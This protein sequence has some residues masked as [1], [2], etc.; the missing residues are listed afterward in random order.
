MR[1][2][3][4]VEGLCLGI[5]WLGLTFWAGLALDYLPVLAGANEMPLAARGVVLTIIAVGLAFILYRWVLRRSF[6]PLADRSLAVLLERRFS[7]F[8]DSLVTAV[9]LT[10]HP[11]HA[12][13][14]DATMLQETSR[15]ALVELPAARLSRLFNYGPLIRGVVGAA[16][17][18]ASVLALAAVQWEAWDTWVHR[19][20]LLGDNTWPRR[21]QIEVVGVELLGPEDAGDRTAD[22]PLIEFR[23][24]ALKVAK[25]SNLRLRVR[26][27]LGA[28][29][30]P[31]VCT[32]Y[33][34][35]ADGERGRASMNRTKRSR[36]EYQN[37]SYADKPLRGILSTIQ[38]DVLGADC[39]V[40]DYT[41]E[42]VDSPAMVVT[43]LDCKFPAYLVDER[44]SLWLP[45]T[46][47][48]ANAT[49][50]P[51]GTDV[52]I[53]AQ[54][55]KPLERVELYNPDTKE[56][57]TLTITGAGDERQRFSYHVSDLQEN[58]TLD[59]TLCDVDQ[60]VTER[61]QRLFVPVVEDEAPRIDAR[62]RGIG[63]AVTPDVM[64]PATGT[65]TDDYAVAK[66][67]F[68]VETTAASTPQDQPKSQRRTWDFPLGAGG[69]VEAVLDCRQWRSLTDGPELKPKDK[70]TLAIKAA[71][72]FN[73]GAS[74][75]NVGSGD[76]YQL[77]VVTPETLL[78]M[79]ESREIGLRR[80]F[81]QIVQEVT[82]CRDLI[83]RTAKPP[84]A[85]K[86][87]P[88]DAAVGKEPGEKQP[89]P[90]KAAERVQ[91][92]RLLRVQQA[93][94]QARKSAQELLG[95]A[96][97]FRDIREELI[98]NRVDTEDRKKRLQEMIADPM[99][100]AGETLFPELDRRLEVLERLLLD[101]LNAKRYNVEIGQ[102]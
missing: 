11:D 32:I 53:R 67:W 14:F 80:R 16:I 8:Q 44:L 59:V 9:E 50:L 31:A 15:H 13:L 98:N 47:P 26:A 90:A 54:T 12:Q 73:L 40:R 35:T 82:Q 46:I 52:T 24:R 74:G 56:T 33:Y 89:D 102:A 72:K 70:L 21:A 61:P 18:M 65:I 39:R 91:S 22:A 1:L 19:I 63:T 58:L 29:V 20:Y 81:E 38:F 42:V 41:I 79:L 93:V 83:Q 88:E 71:D 28:R 4:W 99:Q 45:R 66:T 3:V 84:A 87:D 96:I 64:L 6:V 75:P 68:D 27:Y 17:L 94:Q 86:L 7:A 62:L 5:V 97:A 48:L 76:R 10:E 49:Q 60:V 101:D 43:E 36:D 85:P 69:R 51:R 92:L 57:T 78:A 100:A 2:Y 23:N 25:G 55:N 34:R 30:V 77:D 37:F 95:V